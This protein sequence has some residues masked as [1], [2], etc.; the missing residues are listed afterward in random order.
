M[1]TTFRSTWVAQS[2]KCPTLG[3]RSGHDV[4][5]MRSSPTLDSALSV[6]SACPSP[7]FSISFHPPPHAH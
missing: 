5:V 4:R 2:V 7:S 6:E 1:I 3:F